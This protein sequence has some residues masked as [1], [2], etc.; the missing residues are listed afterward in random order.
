MAMGACM[1]DIPHS[2]IHAHTRACI[3]LMCMYITPVALGS[4]WWCSKLDSISSPGF[5]LHSPLGVPTS[6]PICHL[7]L[8]QLTT[9]STCHLP[10]VVRGAAVYC[11]YILSLTITKDRSYWTL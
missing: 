1:M 11:I 6:K 10:P 4:G 9:K 3:R 2:H 5:I 8:P 7:H